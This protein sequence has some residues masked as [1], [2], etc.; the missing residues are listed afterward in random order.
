MGSSDGN[1]NASAGI[2]ALGDSSTANT[3]TTR[4][5]IVEA[6]TID[7]A[8]TSG[9]MRK[10]RV[11]CPMAAIR[12]QYIYA[13]RGGLLMA[14]N[15]MAAI[16]ANNASSINFSIMTIVF[17]LLKLNSPL[18]HPHFHYCHTKAQTG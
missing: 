16:A 6:G 8:P 4:A 10:N 11:E 9:C 12:A 7:M 13:L 17:K 14:E 1:R 18:K 5:A 15:P 3:P 2:L